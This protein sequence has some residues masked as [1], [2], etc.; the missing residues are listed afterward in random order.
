MSKI[1]TEKEMIQATFCRYIENTMQQQNEIS[2][3]KENLLKLENSKNG[4][5]KFE[6]ATGDIHPYDEKLLLT[7]VK[8]LKHCTQSSNLT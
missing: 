1:Q 4:F 5:N 7:W 3:L 2:Q 6:A 8:L